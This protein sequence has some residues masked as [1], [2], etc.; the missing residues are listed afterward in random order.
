MSRFEGFPMLLNDLGV[1][2]LYLFEFR[3]MFHDGS[4]PV[5]MLVKC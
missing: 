2:S 5:P 3:G 1:V 4:R